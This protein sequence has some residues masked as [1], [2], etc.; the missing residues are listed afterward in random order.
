MTHEPSADPPSLESVLGKPPMPILIPAGSALPDP[1]LSLM[2]PASPGRRERRAQSRGQADS[3]AAPV[4][5]V[6]IG[7][8]EVRAAPSGPAPAARAAPRPDPPQ[9]LGDY[10]KRRDG[11]R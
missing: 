4:V 3:P 11:G 6:T 1:V 7:R 8:V 2:P 10:L 9:S 5:N